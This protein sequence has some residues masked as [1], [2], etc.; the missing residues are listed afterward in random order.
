M[1]LHYYPID[2][3]AIPVQPMQVEDNLAQTEKQ[4]EDHQSNKFPDMCISGP[5][6]DAVTDLD[7]LNPNVAHD[8]EIRH[9][10]RAKMSVLVCLRF[11][12]TRKKERQL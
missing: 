4:V 11:I 8:L 3:S 12:P 7:H 10:G 9:F 1:I 6:S 2:V 5:W